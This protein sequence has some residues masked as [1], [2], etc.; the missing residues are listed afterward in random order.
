MQS[1]LHNLKDDLSED[2]EK[3]YDSDDPEY[4]RGGSGVRVL[5]RLE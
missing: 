5:T 3:L 4:G 2:F 1:Y